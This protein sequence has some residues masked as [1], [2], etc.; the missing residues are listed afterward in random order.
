MHKQY[1]ESITLEKERSDL[2]SGGAGGAREW[3]GQAKVGGSSEGRS[4][5]GTGM[6][7]K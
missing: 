4:P 6:S 2:K 3:E 1:T 5:P 7:S